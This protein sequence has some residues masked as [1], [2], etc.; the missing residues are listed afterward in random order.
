MRTAEEY[1]KDLEKMGTEIHMWG[2]KVDKFWED[3]Q[4]KCGIESMCT[5]FRYA[6][7]PRYEELLTTISPLTGGKISRFT[8][9]YQSPDDMLK[10]VDS[11]REMCH[12]VGHCIGRCVGIDGLHAIGVVSYDIDQQYHTKYHQNFLEFMERFQKQ[13]LTSC[14][15][16]TDVKGDRSLRPHEQADPDLYLRVVDRQKDGIIVRGAKANIT[17][18]PYVEEIIAVPT[19]AFTKE[20][21]D[22]AVA[23]A[24]P[25]DT[26]GIKQLAVSKAPSEKR[27]YEKPLCSRFAFTDSLIIFDDVFVPRERV[28]L[29]GEWDQAAR[30]G[31]LFGNYH[32]HSHCGCIASRIDNLLGACALVAKTNGI[33]KKRHVREKL[34]ELIMVGEMVYACGYTASLKGE[35]TPSG[36]W[37]PNFIY[38]NLGKYFSGTH[39][40]REMEIAQ[41]IAGGLIV[42]MPSDAEYEN[43]ETRKYIEKYLR[44]SA[45]FTTEE[46]IRAIRLV[47]DMA[48]SH[49]SALFMTAG[50]IGAGTPEA[51]KVGILSGYDIKSRENNARR[52]AG[53]REE[54]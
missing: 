49:Y 7:D 5:S 10:R 19:R 38:S 13:D 24:I 39:L 9:L 28:F 8:H 36:I 23:F 29:C 11:L 33:Y 44:G 32:R 25:T 16:V 30:I 20:E 35:K 34:F 15:A 1:K 42:T 3:P 27:P 53:V 41:D 47:E 21:G 43:P 14:G 40:G 52:L 26:K 31:A 6:N 2:K 50:V 12:C 17:T 4:I 46:R 37:A 54:K 18:A 22:W 48:A 51:Q 45:D